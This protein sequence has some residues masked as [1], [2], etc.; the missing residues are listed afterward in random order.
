VEHY[1]PTEEL[2]YAAQS[3]QMYVSIGYDGADSRK[4]QADQTA[5]T[6][7]GC[8]PDP[9]HKVYCLEHYAGKWTIRQ[10]ARLLYNTALKWQASC[11]RVESR[12][13]PPD[14][15][16]IILELDELQRIESR[17]IHVEQFKPRSDKLTR[18]YEVQPMAEQGLLHLDLEDVAQQA[19]LTEMI[20]FTG[21][22]TF[23]DDRVDSAVAGLIPIQRFITQQKNRG[24][25]SK[26]VLAHQPYRPG[27]HTPYG[28]SR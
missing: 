4:T 2:F 1:D 6:V 21:E 10:S 19:L 8:T 28:A 14:K 25:K 22:G 3:G 16:G 23:P 7:W 24:P 15:D 11:V 20:Q 12:C 9:P 26:I 17:P 18:A 27:Q 13:S 5:V